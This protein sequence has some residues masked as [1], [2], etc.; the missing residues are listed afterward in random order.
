MK[1][2][3]IGIAIMCSIISGCATTGQ[4]EWS[5]ELFQ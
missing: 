4:L 5:P 3:I 1:A 2:K